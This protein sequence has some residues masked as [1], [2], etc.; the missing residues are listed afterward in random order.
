LTVTGS[1]TIVSGGD[2]GPGA[3]FV[4]VNR[5]KPFCEAG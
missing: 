5:S 3:K 1:P 2:V 4:T